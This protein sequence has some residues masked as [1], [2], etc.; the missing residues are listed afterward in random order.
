MAFVFLFRVASRV[1]EEL[2]ALGLEGGRV[3]EGSVLSWFQ[4]GLFLVIFWGGLSYYCVW[5]PS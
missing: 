5:R 3:L 2:T 1:R 4:G